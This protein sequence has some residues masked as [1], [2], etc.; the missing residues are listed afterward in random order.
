M[1]TGLIKDIGK[2]VSILP[3]SEGKEFIIETKVLSKEIKIDDSIATN[4]VCLTATEINGN[5]FKVQAV[6]V[7]LEKSTIG[8]LKVGSKLNLELALRPI[9]RLGGHIVQGH[10]NGTGVISAIKKLGKNY[11]VTFTTE[12]KLFKYII[13]EGSIAL[14]GISLTIARIT[15]SSFTVSI[16]PHTWDNTNL[17]TKKIG[18]SVNIEVDMMAKYLENFLRFEEKDSRLLNLLRE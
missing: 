3:N 14:D 10:V 6:H 9:D 7:T 11:E 4:G 16:I 18:D 15:D 2:V 17:H 1:F 5:Q 8:K 12:N 13:A